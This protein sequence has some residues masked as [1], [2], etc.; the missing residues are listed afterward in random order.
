M[1]DTKQVKKLLKLPES[2]NSHKEIQDR[3]DDIGK[4]LLLNWCIEKNGVQKYYINDIEF[5][6]YCKGHEDP[7]VYRHLH[8]GIGRF[9]IHN[10]GIDITLGSKWGD[11]ERKDIYDE[12]NLCGNNPYLCE[13]VI[14]EQLINIRNTIENNNQIVKYGGILIRGIEEIT[15]VE[16]K[17]KINSRT[18]PMIDE[19]FYMGDSPSLLLNLKKLSK[20]RTNKWG[21][22]ERIRVSAK[23]PQYRNSVFTTY[24]YRYFIQ[25]N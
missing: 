10:V 16:P 8:E 14:K 3:F 24:K 4:E 20:P 17:L 21:K 23:N 9:R 13:K 19:L 1:A 15:N 25:P 11:R 6:Y 18:N 12:L 2:V 7:F 22:A 5:Y